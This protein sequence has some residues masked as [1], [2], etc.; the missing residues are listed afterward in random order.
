MKK[1]RQP[2]GFP[3]VFMEL[4]LHLIVCS[5]HPKCSFDSTT[6]QDYELQK[7]VCYN[8]ATMNTVCENPYSSEQIVQLMGD[9]PIIRF[10]IVEIRNFI[11]ELS[12]HSENFHPLTTFVLFLANV[13]KKKKTL[14]SLYRILLATTSI[15]NRTQ[16]YWER[17][18]GIV[19]SVEEW[20]VQKFNLNFSTNVAIKEKRYKLINRWYLTPVKLP[21]IS[22][23]PD[24]CWRCRHGGADYFHMWWSCL[25]LYFGGESVGF[26]LSQITGVTVSIDP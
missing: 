2:R 4:N 5:Q 26:M 18:L 16:I 14:S 10:Q 25:K 13:E 20:Q 11:K 7:P 6:F 9:S 3:E 24:L 12:S 19:L 15:C 22:E 17:D 21:K 8:F 23:Q 1:I